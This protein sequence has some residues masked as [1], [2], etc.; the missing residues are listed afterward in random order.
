MLR[1][2]PA[3]LIVISFLTIC[4]GFYMQSQNHPAAK[5]IIISGLVGETV[6]ILFN[7]MLMSKHRKDKY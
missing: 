2:I 5:F 4:V 3:I 7:R 6:F 1:L